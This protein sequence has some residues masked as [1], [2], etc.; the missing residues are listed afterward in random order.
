MSW[1]ISNCLE[2]SPLP[3]P[4][5]PYSTAGAHQRS[6]LNQQ[7]L[8]AFLSWLQTEFDLAAQIY[9][10]AAALPSIWE[11][12]NGTAI[13]VAGVRLVLIPTLAIGGDELRVPQEWVDI[14]NW[15][16]DYYIS[17]QLDPE[18][19]LL[20]LVGYTSHWQLKTTGVYTA[21]DRT[22]A[23]DGD[24]LLQDSNSLWISWQLYPQAAA[25]A[26][27]SPL[28]PLFQAQANTLL[29]QLGQPSVLFPRLSIPF[30]SW[31]ALLSHGGWRQRLYEQRQGLGS[32]SI[33]QWLQSGMSN[34]IQQLGWER[35]E[36]VLAGTGVRSLVAGMA[37]TLT[38]A[39]H[40]YELRV[41]SIGHS[42]DRTWRIELR[43]AAPDGSVPAGFKL[44][45]LTEDLQG[46]ENNEDVAATPV[47]ALYIDVVLEP[48]ES[49]VWEIEPTPEAY[50]REILRF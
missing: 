33:P 11:V 27:I 23:L 17:L 44:R 15:A 25:R 38:I 2:V 6:R 20:H 10:N 28:P 22:Y 45:L 46:M 48:G 35:R 4:T 26:A 19:C 9:P 31:A 1:M 12:V 8:E 47:E 24:D 40:F 21:R 13:T 5:V 34:F 37:R 29:D 7:C 3:L 32:E 49:L 16:A 36:F 39:D 41:F 30:P 43:S 14:P 42:V 18:N 50:D